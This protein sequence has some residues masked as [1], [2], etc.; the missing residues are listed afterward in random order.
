MTWKVAK[1]FSNVARPLSRGT[2]AFANFIPGV[3]GSADDDPTDGKLDT[4][5]ARSR[6]FARDAAKQ[7]TSPSLARMTWVAIY[8]SYSNEW[9][10]YSISSTKRMV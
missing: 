10:A 5:T 1:A 2:K 8:Q 6:I 9:Y 3:P 7:L 4:A